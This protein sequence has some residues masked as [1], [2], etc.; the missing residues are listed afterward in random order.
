MRRNKFI[1]SI[2]VTDNAIGIYCH[3][4]INIADSISKNI[5]LE[6]DIIENGNIKK[7]FIL[8]EKLNKAFKEIKFVPKT[9]NFV[10]WGENILIREL[11]IDKKELTKISISDY[12]KGQI[13]ETLI[14]P[15]EEA[16][17][18]YN[19]KNETNE[20]VSII[21]AITDKNIIEDYFDV[22]EKSGIR[23]IQMSLLSENIDYLFNEV[24]NDKDKTSI[25]VSLMDHNI[26]VHVV[27]DDILVFGINHECEMMKDGV[28][29]VVSEFIERIANYY[30]FNLRKGERKVGNVILVNFSEKMSKATIKNAIDFDVDSIQL[31]ITDINSDLSWKE[32]HSNVASIASLAQTKNFNKSMNFNIKRT[33]ACNVIASYLLVLTLFIFSTVSLIYIPLVNYSRDIQEL[34]NINTN[35]LTRQQMLEDN[36]LNNDSSSSFEKNYNSAYEELTILTASPS[37]YITDIL[38]LA[39]DEVEILNIELNDSEKRISITLTSI[40]EVYLYDF[41]ITLYEE[42]GI[43]DTETTIKWITSTPLIIVSDNTME[44]TIYYA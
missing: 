42:F 33:K 7:P 20:E 8:L 35:L 4:K 18:T 21:I 36:I 44:V 19:V 34:E 13:N 17:Y 39:N 27:E 43:T 3:N 9:I 12:I 41:S 29:D 22:F 37:K 11:T 10:F 38:S 2:F 31:D 30:E 28:C 14:F 24:A 15:F 6:A 1:T 25:I 40:D 23:N 5:I 16:T 26:S 32:K